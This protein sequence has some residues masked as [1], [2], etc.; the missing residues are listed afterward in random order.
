[1]KDFMW[2]S[3]PNS[4][5]IW[6][7]I[8]IWFILKLTWRA[9]FISVSSWLEFFHRHDQHIFFNKFLY[10]SVYF[11]LIYIFDFFPLQPIHFF[12][13]FSLSKN[14]FRMLI[15]L[16]LSY[17]CCIIHIFMLLFLWCSFFLLFTFS[18]TW[19]PLPRKFIMCS[20][21]IWWATVGKMNSTLRKA[22]PS[23]KV[24]F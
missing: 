1:M 21:H 4:S 11:N 8:F 23:L 6:Q 14:L 18:V 5:F 17:Q 9:K 12:L 13:I 20:I 10:I 22:F 7:F 2:I 16:F 24:K 19:S 15:N 3:H